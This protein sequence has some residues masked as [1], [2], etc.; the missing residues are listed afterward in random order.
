LCCHTFRPRVFPCQRASRRAAAVRSTGASGN[1]LVLRRR[2]RRSLS[3]PEGRPGTSTPVARLRD[4]FR[5]RHAVAGERKGAPSDA[6]VASLP[7]PFARERGP[8]LPLAVRWYCVLPES[9]ATRRGNPFRDSRWRRTFSVSD[10]RTVTTVLRRTLCCHPFR[11]RGY[12]WL[13]A[14][15]R[16]AAVRSTDASGNRVVLRR[17][18]R[19]SLSAPEGRPG[20]STPVARLRDDFR[21]RHAVAG[22]RKGAPSDA[23]VASLPIPFARERGPGLPLAVRWYCVLPKS[24]AT[25]RGDPFRDSRWRR[26]YLRSPTPAPSCRS[27][28]RGAAI[29]NSTRSHAWLRASRRA[30]AVRSTDTSGDPACYAFSARRKQ[31]RV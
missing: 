9:R 10:A 8:G 4:D 24:R 17:R 12:P 3:A 18:L 5:P 1:R 23:A 20:T 11:P 22:V 30:V 21:P 31:R 19:R 16:A 28:A 2:L 29:Q 26:T 15:R 14:S 25:R 27:R 6:A 13:R 7:I